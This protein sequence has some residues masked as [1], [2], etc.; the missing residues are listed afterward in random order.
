MQVINMIYVQIK[1]NKK[2]KVPF[3]VLENHIFKNLYAMLY[4]FV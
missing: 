3:S 2:Y 1:I 4:N